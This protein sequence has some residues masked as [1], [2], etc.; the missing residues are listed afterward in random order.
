MDNHGDFLTI[1]TTLED[2]EW[3]NFV[4]NTEGGHH[5]QTSLWAQVKAQ[6]GWKPLRIVVKQKNSIVAGCQA[7]VHH[8][9]ILGNIGYVTKGPLRRIED[10]HIIKR[11][12]EQ[13]LSMCKAHKIKLIAVQPPT[14]GEFIGNILAEYNFSPSTLELAPAATII[15]DVSIGETGLLKQLQKRTRN[16]INHGKR[17]GV[18]VR[19]GT[20]EDLPTFY[21]LHIDTSKRQSFLP[22]PENYFEAMYRILGSHGY[23][24]LLLSEFNGEPVSAGLVVPFRDTVILKVLGWSGKYKEVKPNTALLW[25]ILLWAKDN[26]YRYVDLEGVNLDGARKFL[27]GEPLPETIRNSPDF[28][29]YGYGGQVI[30]L[31][32]AYDM[33]FNPVY[34]WLFHRVKFRVAQHDFSSKI[35]DLFRKR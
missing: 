15:I 18:V 24:Q 16:D 20:E 27:K 1:T 22:Y 31:P 25:G 26:G 9:R 10:P 4:A 17:A 33:V 6:L 21:D 7:L 29:K 2:P 35:T 5:V 23:I 28:Q 12:V 34:R 32:E 30:L 3:D 13:L 14:N 19:K 11:I 8:Y